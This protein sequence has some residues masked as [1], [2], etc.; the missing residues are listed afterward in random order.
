[1]RRLWAVARHTF[2]EATRARLSTFYMFVLVGTIVLAG[3]VSR[4]GTLSDQ[5]RTFLVYSVGLCGVN[6]SFMTIMLGCRIVSKEIE[7]H[8]IFSPLTKPVPRWQHSR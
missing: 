6:L 2:I 1:M 8:H 5:L 7:N 4:G 3:L